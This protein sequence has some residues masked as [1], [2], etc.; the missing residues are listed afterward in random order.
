MIWSAYAADAQLSIT[1]QSVQG[2]P[3]TSVVVGKPFVLLVTAR[4]AGR[5]WSFPRVDGLT[6]FH[7]AGQNSQTMQTRSNGTID[8]EMTAQ[9]TLMAE[10]PGTYILGPA[11]FSEL[12]DK[13]TGSVSIEVVDGG[14]GQK[15]T[16]YEAPKLTLKLAKAD[17]YMGK[18]FLSSYDSHGKNLT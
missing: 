10:K 13:K 15:K 1:V 4:N 11:Q 8:E 14:K 5:I 7:L 12:P 9:Y 18:R 3:L 6:S 17:A 16:E 2:V